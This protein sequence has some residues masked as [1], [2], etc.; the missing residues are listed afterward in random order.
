MKDYDGRWHHVITDP[1]IIA[2]FVGGAI[3]L[4]A[5]VSV[6]LWEVKW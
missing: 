3:I 5:A 1:T 2:D 4:V 6:F